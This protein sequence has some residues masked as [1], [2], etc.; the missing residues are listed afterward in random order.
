[1][2]QSPAKSNIGNDDAVGRIDA[3][4][5]QED[6]EFAEEPVKE[7]APKETEEV[8]EPEAVEAATEE[9]EEEEQPEEESEVQEIDYDTLVQVKSKDAE[10]NEVAEDV[11]I[12]DLISQ[13]MLQS[14]YT[15]KTQDLAKQ[16]AEVQTELQKGIEQ[17]RQQYISAL[18]AQQQAFMELLTPEVQNLDQLAETDPAEFVRVQ[19][20]MSK[21]QTAIQKVESQR[22][23]AIQKHQEYM[24]TQVLPKQQ[25]LLKQ[26]IPDWSDQTKQAVIETGK[27]FGL[28]DEELGSIVDHRQIRILHELSRLT[29]AEKSF[30]DKKAVAS[31]KVVE[32]PKVVKSKKTP[33]RESKADASLERLK[34]TGRWQDAVGAIAETLTDL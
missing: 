12:K 30:N 16:R 15:R 8:E 29:N 20:R 11:S 25:E 9:P 31:K 17:E 6:G 4:L 7:S 27:K 23:E 18:E 19:N 32:K 13:R 22:Q 33:Q 10:G 14:D 5:A 28:T 1:M 3:L 21:Y 24:Q 26:A 34:K 2:D